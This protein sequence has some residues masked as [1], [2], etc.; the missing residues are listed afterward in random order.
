MKN[1]NDVCILVQARLGST[2]VPRKMLRPFAETTLVEVLFE[3]LKKSSVFSLDNVVFSAWESELK[4]VAKK[5]GINIFHR[6]KK[7]AYSEGDPLTEIYEW[8][9]KLPFKY[10]VSISA[11]NPL[12]DITTIDGFVENFVNS[13]KEGAFAVFKKKTYYW[14]KDKKP[15]T[16][17][18]G[19]T[20]LNTKIV[21]PVYEA[22]HCLYA[23]RM[24]IISDG[25]WMDTNSPPNLE[26]FV[27]DEIE[28]FDI[29][30]EWQFKLGEILYKNKELLS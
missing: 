24:N 9:D 17:W 29:D 6:S 20:S 11:C 19:T 26:L 13:D 8:H 16:D 30:Y 12:L 21:D 2:R 22:A 25:Y 4:E 27:V 1:I 5:H 7:S 14:D 3:K 10:V 23:S 28:S 18:K 15:L